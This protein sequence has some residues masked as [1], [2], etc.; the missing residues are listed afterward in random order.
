MSTRALFNTVAEGTAYQPAMFVVVRLI[1][2][3][4]QKLVPA[5]VDGPVGAVVVGGHV[6]FTV[7][8]TWSSA[9]APCDVPISVAS[10]V[11][12]HLP[13]LW[14]R[15]KSIVGDILRVCTADQLRPDF[16]S[17]PLSLSR[18]TLTA[19]RRTGCTARSE[20]GP[21]NPSLLLTT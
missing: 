15:V 11:V 10:G 4:L 2:S 18:A 16:Q 14:Q 8:G 19:G 21:T 3:L 9:I 5:R 20:R 17:Q 13:L 1:P 7:D 6:K 12:S